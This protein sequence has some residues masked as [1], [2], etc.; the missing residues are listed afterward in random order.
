M[1]EKIARSGSP[2]ILI[3]YVCVVAALAA[4]ANCCIIVEGTARLRSDIE[5]FCVLFQFAFFP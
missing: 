4:A 1:E 5:M 3:F 2:I